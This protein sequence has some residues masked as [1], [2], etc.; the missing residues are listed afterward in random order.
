MLNVSLK[1]IIKGTSNVAKIN[2]DLMVYY[3]SL[4]LY[5]ALHFSKI[6]DRSHSKKQL[7]RAR[8]YSEA[9]DLQNHPKLPSFIQNMIVPIIHRNNSELFSALLA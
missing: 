2:K 1:L 5:S 9:R 7:I 3:T 8:C 6:K 4:L